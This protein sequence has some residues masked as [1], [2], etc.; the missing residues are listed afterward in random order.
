MI[1]ILLIGAGRWGKN[2]ISTLS[3]FDNVN[4]KVADRENW[5]HLVDD[6]HCNGVIIAT[7]PDSHI[8]IACHAL[9]KNIPVM[10]EKPLS[11][12]FSEAEKLRQ[13]TAPILVNHI[14]L[15]SDGYQNIKR[16]VGGHGITKITSAGCADGPVRNYSSL[17]DYGPHDIS[18]ILDLLNETPEVI[19][20]HEFKS[21][22]KSLYT[23]NMNF[24]DTFTH[25]VIGNCSSVRYR[26]LS[27]ELDG[28]NVSYDDI[29]SKPSNHTLPLVNALNV[30]IN[31]IDGKPDNRLGL[32]LSFKVLEVLEHCENYLIINK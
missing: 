18:M 3:E 13:F 5:R 25:S 19:K 22:N 28:I 1:D 31:A 10:I 30:F 4:L 2:Y 16:I 15:F 12:S 6:K 7:P 32:E 9:E 26:T 11:L 17:W 23:L 24:K 20:I 21:G 8:D 27:I 29:N 14:H